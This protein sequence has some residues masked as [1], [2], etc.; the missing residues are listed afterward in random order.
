MEVKNI[1]VRSPF[2]VIEMQTVGGKK[3]YGKS[4][5]QVFMSSSSAS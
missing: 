4:T 2:P 1:Y 5:F 3:P